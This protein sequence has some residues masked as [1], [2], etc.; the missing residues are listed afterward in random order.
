MEQYLREKLRYP[1]EAKRAG[2]TGKVHVGFIVCEDG[3]IYNPKVLRG[4]GHGCDEE[5]LRLVREMPN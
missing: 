2:N 3:S 5:A 1:E 4:I